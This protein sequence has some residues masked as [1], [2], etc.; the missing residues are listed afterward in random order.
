VNPDQHPF[1]V[2]VD[3]ARPRSQLWRTVT[4]GIL[5]LFV[6]LVWTIALLFVAAGSGLV[7]PRTIDAL[8]GD[9]ARDFTYLE[10]VVLFVVVLATLWGLGLGVWLALRVIH[11][12][13][14]SSLLSADGRM[15][16]RQFATGCA[17]AAVFLSISLALSIVTGNAPRRSDVEIQPWL[18]ALGPLCAV[19]VLQ[20]GSEELMFRG[21]LPQQLAAR[22]RSPVGAGVHFLRVGLEEL[23]Q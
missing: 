15:D 6:W 14:L 19:I 10:S 21:Y 20:A 4:G 2:W 13:P 23:S 17:I 22:F 12:R 5:I 16:R 18:L 3:A 9:T 11:K 8:F 1:A 7:D